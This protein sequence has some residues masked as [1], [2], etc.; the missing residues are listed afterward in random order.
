MN[1]DLEL[2]ISFLTPIKKLLLDDSISEI[3]GNPNGSWW[4]EKH[5]KLYPAESLHFD[6]KALRTGLEVI[7][8]KLGR[9]LEEAHPILNAQLPDGSR[10]AAVLPPVV[11]PFPS[12][13]IRKFSAVRLTIADLIKTGALSSQL[14]EYLAEQIA[15]G[16]TLLIS[17][18]TSS[19]KTTFL[20]ALTDYIPMDERIVVIEDTRELRLSRPNLLAAECQTGAHAGTVSFN[21]LLKSALRWRPDRIILGEVRGDEARTLLDSFN[22]GHGGSMATIHASTAVRALR[23]FGQLAMRS[24]QQT[25]SDDI[26]SEI[27][28]S[29]QLVIQ[30]QRYPD[31][32]R[33]TEVIEVDGYDR[34]RKVFGYRTIFDRTRED[35][36]ANYPSASVRIFPITGDQND[37]IA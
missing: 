36:D 14:A 4:F 7:A 5:G 17:G 27:G 26:A 16:K 8:N 25:N 35:H 19:G 34:D 33:V 28:E 1:R 2:L 30:L 29:V 9:K 32:R 3:M 20:N 24:H 23:K 18:G 37:A 11:E 13:T 15:G 31:G 21:D 10:L 22:T 6:A 12:V